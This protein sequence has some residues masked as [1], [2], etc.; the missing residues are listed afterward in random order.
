MIGSKGKTSFGRYRDKLEDH[1][2]INLKEWETR[3]KREF[4]RCW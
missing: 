2:K 4:V 3:E 1:I